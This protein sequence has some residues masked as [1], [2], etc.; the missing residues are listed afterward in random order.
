MR[1]FSGVVGRM[2]PFCYRYDQLGRLD[3]E[4]CNCLDC[5][6]EYECACG[7]VW[8]DDDGQPC[9]CGDDE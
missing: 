7:H 9:P 3:D 8:S 1:I 2:S 6:E 5:M 4:S